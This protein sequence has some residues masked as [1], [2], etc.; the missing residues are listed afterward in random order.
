MIYHSNNATKR[1][2]FFSL[3]LFTLSGFRGIAQHHAGVDCFT[4]HS[5]LQ[6]GGTLFSDSLAMSTASGVRFTLVRPTGGTVT[7]DN[8]NKDGNIFAT[9]ID[10][11]SFLMKVGLLTSRTWHRLPERK[12]CNTCHVIGG[13][14]STT[15]TASLPL[16]HTAI[17]ADNRC[18]NCHHFPATQSIERLRTTGV[19]NV[20]R[21]LPTTPSSQVRIGART[22]PFDPAKQQIAPVRPDIF[23][24]GYYSMFD[25]ILAVAKE[26][27][28]PIEYHY[29]DSCGTH[30][31]TKMNGVT[32]D[33]WYHWSYDAGAQNSNEIQL[34]RAN[35]WDE[36]L[37]RPGAWIQIVTG[38]NLAEIKRE[39][40][41]EMIRQRTLGHVIPSVQIAINPS[42]YQGNP[43][44]SH[45]ITVSKTFTDVRVTPHNIRSTGFDSPYSK[46]FQPGVVTSM[47]ILHSLKDQGKLSVVTGVFYDRFA[48][49]YIDSYYIVE[50]GF[51]GIGTAHSS[52]RQGFVYVT[53]NGAFNRLP[54]GADNK[55][56]MTSDINVIHAPDFSYWRWIELGNPYYERSVPIAVDPTVEEDYASLDRGF[57]LHVPY[58]NPSAG[59]IMVAY[60][61]FQPGHV[62]IEAF[63][64]RGVRLATIVDADDVNIGVHRIRWSPTELPSGSYIVR[65][66]VGDHAQLRTVHLVK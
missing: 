53:E 62:T 32:N 42:N 3:C 6:L 23:A 59:E 58:P 37:W 8:S 29:D 4:C 48:S 44:E 1:F 61:L 36:A 19:L 34:K 63:D 13:N 21:S 18:D 31:I 54:N 64:M 2:M 28:I 66:T 5:N 15:R 11:G 30:F 65:M 43:A 41:E 50:M 9:R 57:N 56:H 52:G 20:N 24:A 35:R 27:A 7:L 39:Y 25:V 46:P 33:F 14:G 51:P 22:Y 12:S 55:L 45:R 17:P 16:F 38:E 26:N 49:N 60:N 40:K 10:S 47:D